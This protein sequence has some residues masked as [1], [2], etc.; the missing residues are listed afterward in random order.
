M[1][2]YAV[3][4]ITNTVARLV[5]GNVLDEN[6]VIVY[7]TERP[8]EGLV[9][10]GEIADFNGL[11]DVLANMRKISDEA[12]RL[13]L[14]ISEASVIVPPLGLE[15]FQTDKTTNVVSPTSIIEAID[16]QNVLSLV[17]KERVTSGSEIVDIIPDFFVLEQTGT[18]VEPPIGQKS[19]T[20]SLR[21]KVH[22]MPSRVI[23]DYKRVVE[24]AGIH[25]RRLMVSSYATLEY[26][27]STKITPNNYLI[28]D[29]GAGSTTLSL[30]G[31]NCLFNSNVILL[32][33]NDLSLQIADEFDIDPLKATELMEL[34]GISD[35][36][37]SFDPV[38]SSGIS[39][40]T[41]TDLNRVIEDF[42]REFYFKQLDVGLATL[43]T[44]YSQRVAKLPIIVTGGFSKLKGVQKLLQEKFK[45]NESV[46]FVSPHVVGARN[47]K[48]CASL[49]ALV[50]ST[51]YKGT[52]SDQ[53]AR[54]SPVERVGDKSEE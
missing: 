50:V 13:R 16:I 54:V 19:N 30:V 3:I 14:T 12:L 36:E 43:L 37:M 44:G 2:Q 10:R 46:T 31:G 38:I 53:R 41:V 22:S 29:M 7:S 49:G 35:R 47:P 24:S 48:Y 40:R 23:D 25:V 9:T 6:P 5:V 51:H 33:G 20:L 39:D 34:Y 27:K 17:Q 21:A 32:G 28:M 15:I 18:F 45:E 8:I 11:V 4:E 1:K 52:L 42:F 26:L